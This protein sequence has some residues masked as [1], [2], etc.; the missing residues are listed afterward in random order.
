MLTYAE[1][2]AAAVLS[3]MTMEGVSSAREAGALLLL[4]GA[5]CS[6]MLTYADVC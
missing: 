4:K 1:Q 3:R 5:A 2:V 6:G